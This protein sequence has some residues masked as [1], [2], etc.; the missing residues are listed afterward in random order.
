VAGAQEQHLHLLVERRRIRGNPGDLVL[1]QRR[2]EAA[3]IGELI[4]VRNGRVEGLPAA[5][6]KAGHGAVLPQ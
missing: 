3:D 5:A 6:R 1:R 4:Q 2:A